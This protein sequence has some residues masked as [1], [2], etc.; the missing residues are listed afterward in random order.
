MR[1]NFATSYDDGMWHLDRTN[2]MTNTLLAQKDRANIVNAI[3]F[4][5]IRHA[6]D[7]KI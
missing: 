3:T 5:V 7:L 4:F 2:K 6:N 1:K